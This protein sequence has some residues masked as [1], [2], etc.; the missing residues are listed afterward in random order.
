MMEIMRIP[1]SEFN[2]IKAAFDNPVKDTHEQL[3]FLGVRPAR[4]SHGRLFMVREVE[5]LGHDDYL[6]QS[7]GAV[8]PRKEVQDRVFRE[9]LEKGLE[10]FTLHSFSPSSA[11]SATST[12]GSE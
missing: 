11:D 8:Q 4:W 1:I 10:V 12:C 9:M 6:H 5:L 2:A 7:A 3:C